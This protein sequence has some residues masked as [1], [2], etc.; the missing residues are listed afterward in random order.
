[1]A[2]IQRVIVRF[3]GPQGASG[4]GGGGGAGYAPINSP[5][6]TGSPTAPTPTGGSNNTLLATTAFVQSA[7]ATRAL[8]S[9]THTA[10]EVSDFASAVLALLSA[11]FVAGSNV[12]INYSSLAGTWTIASTGGGGGGSAFTTS[13]ELD[14][15]LSDNT[16]NGF[17]V[18]S[19]NP[20]LTG[21]PTAPTATGGTNT[22]QIATTAFVQSAV[23][24]AVS[25]LAPLNS[26]GLTGTPTAP[27]AAG[28]TNN[29]QIA[30]T[31][32]VQAAVA[33]V[34]GSTTQSIAYAASITPVIASGTLI[35]VGTLTGPILINNPTGSP[36]DGQRFTFH[37][38]Q[39][40]TGGRAITWGAAFRFGIDLTSADL[41]TAPN[42]ENRIVFQYNSTNSKYEAVGLTRF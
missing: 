5:G 15:L 14:A 3:P 24:T 9:H 17:V 30:T 21:T 10:S 39:D 42:V 29:V 19:N 36:T 11:R 7:V 32:F 12:T 27:T 33:G 37:L 23:N 6:F 31:A 1:M 16:G 38:N 34:G 28:G 26:P 8:S 25:T 35:K 41:S 40:A 20:A 18:F 13:A 22:V 4:G 2:S